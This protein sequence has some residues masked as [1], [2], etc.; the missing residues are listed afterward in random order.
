[1]AP[2]LSKASPNLRTNPDRQNLRDTQ[3]WGGGGAFVTRFTQQTA[4][5]STAFDKLSDYIKTGQSKFPQPQ[6]GWSV[7][8]ANITRPFI[9]VPLQL[10]HDETILYHS[11]ISMAAFVSALCSWVD[12]TD[13]D[14]EIDVHIDND[15]DID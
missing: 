4:F 2:R 11:D 12:G 5:S 14:V 8:A 6:Q 9:F 15:I 7:Q 10:P 1:M 3:G 13:F